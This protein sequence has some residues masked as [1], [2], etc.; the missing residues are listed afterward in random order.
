[1]IKKN[2][3]TNLT[4]Y[5]SVGLIFPAKTILLTFAPHELRAEEA[6]CG[7]F[8]SS[9]PCAHIKYL[10]SSYLPYPQGHTYFTDTYL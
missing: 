5:V 1:M 6:Q 8:L 4:G 3:P 10:G 9:L 2:Q 7:S